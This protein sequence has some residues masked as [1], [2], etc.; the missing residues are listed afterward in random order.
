[1]GKYQILLDLACCYTENIESCYWAKQPTL[2][3]LEACIS[4]GETETFTA[5]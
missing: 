3:F 4:V 5:V 1:M 2:S